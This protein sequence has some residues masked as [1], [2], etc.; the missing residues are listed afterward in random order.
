MIDS[1]D[2]YRFPD[3]LEDRLDFVFYHP[4]FDKIIDIKDNFKYPL[5]RIG[6]YFI[7][8]WTGEN[9]EIRD[10]KEKK[11]LYVK[12]ENVIDNEIIITENSEFLSEDELRRLS[13]SIPKQY[14]ILVTRVAS[15]GRCAVVGRGFKCAI[16]DNILCFELNVNKVEPFFI[17]RFINSLLG[18]I[19]F[20]RS[21]AGM[22][23]GVLTYDRVGD[24]YIGVPSSKDKQ[25]RILEQVDLIE[26]QASSLENEANNKR[27][28]AEKLLLSELGIVLPMEEKIDYYSSLFDDLENRFGYGNYHPSVKQLEVSFENSKYDTMPLSELITLK[29]DSIEP[30]KNPDTEYYYIGLENI[31]SNTGRLK[32]IQKLKGRDI[33]SKSNMFKKGQLMFSGLRP[34]LNKCFILEDYEEAIGS[35]EL[36]ICES[37]GDVSLEFLKLYLLSEVTLRQ[38]K[39]VLSGA[40]YPRLD[41]VDFV[42]LKIIIPRE[43][44]EQVRIV[45]TVEAKIKEAEEK[46]QQTKE[47]WQEAKDT[48]E[49]LILKEPH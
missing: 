24:L 14:S 49:R 30:S 2:Y 9:L 13:N 18:Q 25:K 6:E 10:T 26:S 4:T 36:F 11:Y 41:E 32:D 7:E 16:S 39:W 40:S 48:F 19:Q 28:G 1:F 38:T 27:Y 42:N 43:Y 34:Y 12:V 37:K 45:E 47:K 8:K 33:S 20:L 29:Y 44:N 3:V 5:H 22:G 17:A 46:E 15:F 31:E 23:R 21:A 35:A